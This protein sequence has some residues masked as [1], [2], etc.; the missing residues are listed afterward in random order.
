MTTIFR[1]FH[2][3]II[4]LTISFES[5]YKPMLPLK[6]K[7]SKS[8][9]NKCLVSWGIP[10][11]PPTPGEIFLETSSVKASHFKKIDDMWKITGIE[12]YSACKKISDWFNYPRTNIP[13]SM[14]LLPHQHKPYN[15]ALFK[16]K[17]IKKHSKGEK[18]FRDHKKCKVSWS[19]GGQSISAP[20]AKID[21][22]SI[23]LVKITHC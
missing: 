18:T 1:Y 22:I 9:F 20:R 2:C 19:C 15:S 10:S 23:Y 21:Q 13:A 4:G 14:S 12:P 7:S 6:C 3:L 11:P 5:Y 17:I 16:K 8:M